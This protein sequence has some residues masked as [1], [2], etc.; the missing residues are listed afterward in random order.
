[1]PEAAEAGSLTKRLLGVGEGIAVREAEIAV[2][3]QIVKRAEGA[4]LR[5]AAQGAAEKRAK[6]IHDV[7]KAKDE[8]AHGH[9]TTAVTETKEGVNVISSSAKYLTRDQKA[10]LKPSEVAASGPGH[11]EVTG[12]NFAKQQ[13]LTPT[14][15]AASRPI[16]QECQKFLNENG[17]EPLSPLR[18]IKQPQ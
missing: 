5:R 13:G 4:A 16:C 7:V 11:A 9:M 14:G 10:M 12:V 15:T 2:E 8:F 18:P 17:I 1:M 6:E 3:K